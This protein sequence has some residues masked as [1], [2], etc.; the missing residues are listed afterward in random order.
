[1]SRES[2]NKEVRLVADY[3]LDQ[4]MFIAQKNYDNT[5]MLYSIEYCERIGEYAVIC[6]KVDYREE[7]FHISVKPFHTAIVIKEQLDCLKKAF[8]I[9]QK[10]KSNIQRIVKE[11]ED[12]KENDEKED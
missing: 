1:M 5:S 8:E 3:L 2:F 9:S 7:D 10:L 6:V 4:G 11:L 12:N